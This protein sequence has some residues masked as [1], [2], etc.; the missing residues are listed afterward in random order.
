MVL[1]PDDSPVKAKKARLSAPLHSEFVAPLSFLTDA[2]EDP[3]RFLC[4]GTTGTFGLQNE[5][6]VR[7]VYVDLSGV[8]I[9]AIESKYKDENTANNKLLVILRG[10][11][12]IGKS[13][14]L[15]YLI[16]QLMKNTRKNNLEDI[17]IFR[18]SK[19]SKNGSG[20]VRNSGIKYYISK[21]GEE[22]QQGNY[23]D[24]KDWEAL[25]RGVEVIIM[26]GCSMAFDLEHFTGTVIVAAPPSQF[27]KNL[28]DE[29]MRKRWFTVPPLEKN[30]AIEMA[31][32]INVPEDI[33]EENYLHSGGI[34]RYLFEEGLGKKKVDKAVEGAL[35]P[36]IMKM[37]SSQAVSK[38][39]DQVTVHSLVLWSVEKDKDGKY[40]FEENPVFSLISRYVERLVSAKLVTETIENLKQAR[41][42][43][44]PL[45]GAEGYAEAL[46][47]AYAIRKLQAG[48]TFSMRRLSIGLTNETIQLVVPPLIKEPVIVETNSLSEAVVPFATLR[49]LNESG[50]QLARILWPM[51]PNFPTFDC[52]YIDENGKAWS[53]QM[54]IAKSHDLKNSGAMNV[55][56][57]FDKMLG[58]SKPDKY[59][60]VFVVPE[61]IS[62]VYQQQ[63]FT[64][65]FST[66]K[67]VTPI[68]VPGRFE[69]WVIGI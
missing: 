45:S 17:A 56:Q 8:I 22:V 9:D 43:L 24:S 41:A 4:D 34:T 14:Y 26:D 36:S 57:Y 48:G 30:E 10:S 20:G 12:G 23:S 31:E 67:E 2:V 64:G 44:Q 29:I 46:F 55:I 66:K 60:A 51:S 15:A 62:G 65:P 6:V 35:T 32:K 47:D 27:T 28:E 42:S 5:A 52:F 58:T 16:A 3:D 21:R 61:E 59:P 50:R 37:V 53:M 7:P 11:S 39:E 33:V 40:M 54:T 38:G 18:A 19:S 69:Q 1:F 49:E 63:K 13:T 25:L 68:D